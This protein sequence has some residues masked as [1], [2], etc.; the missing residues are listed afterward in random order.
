MSSLGQHRHYSTA[1]SFV[2]IQLLTKVLHGLQPQVSL[3]AS[4]K[5][6]FPHSALL[7]ARSSSFR[8]RLGPSRSDH[9]RPPRHRSLHRSKWPPLPRLLLNRF[10]PDHLASRPCANRP[11]PLLPTSSPRLRQSGRPL[12]MISRQKSSSSTQ[13]RPPLLPDSSNSVDLRP[14]PPFTPLGPT[15]PCRS[16]RSTPCPSATNSNRPPQP[17]P[18]SRPRRPTSP[19]LPQRPT[20]D[21]GRLR[22]STRPRPSRSTASSA[23]LL[24]RRSR[25]PAGGRTHPPYVQ[26]SGTHLRRVRRSP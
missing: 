14:P 21:P 8:C 2:L 16:V 13:R 20:V 10:I 5:E 3:S 12:A 1:T 23:H 25:P 24:A 17:R 18:V 22:D 15:G 19:L 4:I 9:S 26:R 11:A 7:S 6:I